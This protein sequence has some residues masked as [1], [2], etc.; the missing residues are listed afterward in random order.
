[1]LLNGGMAISGDRFLSERIIAQ[2]SQNLTPGLGDS[3]SLG[4]Q[5]IPLGLGKVKEESSMAYGHTGFTGTSVFIV[6][7]RGVAAILLTNRVH[8]SRSEQR[9]IGLRPKFHELVLD[10]TDNS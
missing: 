2:F 4:F 9:L 10:L 7:E 3:R 6:P 5:L 1:M 8:P